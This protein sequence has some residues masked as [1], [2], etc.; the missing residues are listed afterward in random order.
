MAT[1]AELQER[2]RR[3]LAAELAGGCHDRVVAG[4][5]EKL[6]ATPLA[7]P[8]PQVREVLSGYGQMGADER[9][10]ALRE[11][12]ALTAA[13]YRAG[14]AGADM[15]RVSWGQIADYTARLHPAPAPRAVSAAPSPQLVL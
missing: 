15:L 7:G 8:F 3:P 11:A 9:A 2:L 12:L 10:G 14:A 1:V 5:V 4:G 6:L 13:W